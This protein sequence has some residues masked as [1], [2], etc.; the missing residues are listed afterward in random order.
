[1]YVY[2]FWFYNFY[3]MSDSARDRE[4]Q[5]AWMSTM[6]SSERR[7]S[8]NNQQHQHQDQNRENFSNS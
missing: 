2:I 7:T 6:S 8:I 5:Q 4:V 1:M 3:V